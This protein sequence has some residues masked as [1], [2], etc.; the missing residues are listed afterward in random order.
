MG[1]F[2]CAGR[3]EPFFLLPS[4]ATGVDGAALV[5]VMVVYCTR[6]K[7]WVVDLFFSTLTTLGSTVAVEILSD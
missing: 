6:R 2:L 1:P 5:V 3:L 4:S 7:S